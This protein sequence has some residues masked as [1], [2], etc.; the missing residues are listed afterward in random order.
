MKEAAIFVVGAMRTWNLSLPASLPFLQY[1]MYTIVGMVVLSDERPACIN[2]NKV[3]KS[4]IT[5]EAC[6]MLL[7]YV[8]S[9]GS[10]VM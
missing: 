4:P 7:F 8:A 2:Y 1:S 6:L 9:Y 5:T 10:I 3:N